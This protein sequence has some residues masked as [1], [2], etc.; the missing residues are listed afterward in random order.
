[1]FSY[2]IK[3]DYVNNNLVECFNSWINNI[4]DFPIVDLVD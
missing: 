3:C 4:K 1:V 2:A